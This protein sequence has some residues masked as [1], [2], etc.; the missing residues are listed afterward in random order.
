MTENTND[1]V[2]THSDAPAEGGEAASL[3][4]IR[5]HSEDPAEGPDDED[6]AS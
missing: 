5:V 4:N 1:E 2:R 3:E 6:G